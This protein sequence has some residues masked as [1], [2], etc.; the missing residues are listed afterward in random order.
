M[1]L[2][3]PMLAVVSSPTVQITVQEWVPS[4]SLTVFPLSGRVGDVFTF[5]G[6]FLV[7][8]MWLPGRTISLYLNGGLVGTGI[9]GD[10]GDYQISWVADRAGTLIFHTEG[11][12]P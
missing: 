9:T 11:E 10:G 3:V 4:L 12:Y 8:D 5:A 6:S 7:D 2:V 1:S